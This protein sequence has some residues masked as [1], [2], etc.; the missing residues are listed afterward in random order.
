[1]YQSQCLSVCIFER[2]TYYF[3]KALCHL[4]FYLLGGASER[5]GGGGGGA[6]KNDLGVTMFVF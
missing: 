4:E 6:E 2:R 5:G 3:I 1:M